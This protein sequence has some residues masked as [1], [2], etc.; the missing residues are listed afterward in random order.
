MT[1]LL[2]REC[3]GVALYVYPITVVC[4]YR[5]AQTVHQRL[6]KKGSPSSRLGLLL[7]KTPVARR[8]PMLAR[9]LLPGATPPALGAPHPERR[10]VRV[11]PARLEHARELLRGRE[12]G[13]PGRG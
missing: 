1:G 2:I 8:V 12:D 9:G 11:V 5:A 10:R 7:H 3:I 6:Y 13:L 4:W